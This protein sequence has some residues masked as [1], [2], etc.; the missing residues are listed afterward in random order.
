MIALEEQIIPIKC[1]LGEVASPRKVF[2]MAICFLLQEDFA[3]GAIVM[4]PLIQ[5]IADNPMRMG[6]GKTTPINPLACY[7]LQIHR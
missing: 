6:A 3:V 7:C 4:L 1:S 5:C 2:G